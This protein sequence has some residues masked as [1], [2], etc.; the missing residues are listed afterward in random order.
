[1]GIVCGGGDVND[2]PDGLSHFIVHVQ[3]GIFFVFGEVMNRMVWALLSS[4]RQRQK[5]DGVHCLQTSELLI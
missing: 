1:M 2:F 5:T 3:M 4:I